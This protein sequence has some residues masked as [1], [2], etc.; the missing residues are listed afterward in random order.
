MIINKTNIKALLG[1]TASTYDTR[2]DMHIPILVKKLVEHCK[3]HFVKRGTDGFVYDDCDMVFT[4]TTCSLETDIPLSNGD[5]I[6]IMNT[7]YNNDIFQVNSYESNIL[8]IETVK[9]FKAEEI[10]GAII[11][12]LDLPETFISVI[13]GYVSN[14]IIKGKDNIVNE[15]IDDYSVTFKASDID[16][17]IT[18]NGSILNNYRSPVEIKF[19]GDLY[20]NDTID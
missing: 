20:L 8:T 19:L 2:I 16:S 3:R 9:T 5:F 10:T 13:A 4:T 1:I 12:L 7:N 17:W 11:A 18:S 15:K 6:S 14:F